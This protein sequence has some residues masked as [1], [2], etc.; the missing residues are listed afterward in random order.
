MVRTFALA[1]LFSAAALIPAKAEKIETAIFA[2][3]CFWC[4]ESDM[5][6]V[7]GVKSTVS[8][9]AGGTLENPTYE[10]HEGHKEV[11][12]VTYD[13]DIVTFDQLAATFLRTIDVTDDGGQF[14]DRGSAYQSAIF[15]MD[16]AQNKAAVAA[17]KAAETDLGQ[18]IVTPVIAFTTYTDAEDYHQNYYQGENSV[19]TRFG[20]VKQSE[21]Y[22]RYRKGCGRTDRVKEVWG[23]KAYMGVDAHS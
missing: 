6:H 10:N 23:D 12:K 14:C 4:V 3:G 20:Y 16:D 17:V 5:D 11:V 19:L 13:A 21:A 18:K 1:A 15:T 9:Y 8:G 22:Q 7:K 2:G